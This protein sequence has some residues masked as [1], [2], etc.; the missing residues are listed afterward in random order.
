VEGVEP[1]AF[2]TKFWLILE[3][4]SVE[5]WTSGARYLSVRYWLGGPIGIWNKRP[6]V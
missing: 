4:I 2:E 3:G 5:C 6:I 1:E